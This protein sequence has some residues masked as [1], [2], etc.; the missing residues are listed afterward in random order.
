M[1]GNGKR[2]AQGTPM[3]A[4]KE[5]VEGEATKTDEKRNER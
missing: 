4:G 1:E 5:K 3:H 2:R